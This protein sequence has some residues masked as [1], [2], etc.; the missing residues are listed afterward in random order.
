MGLGYDGK[1][2]I[3]AFDHRGSFQKK[4]FGIEGD[5]TP[6]ETKII[7]DAK[8]L[9]FEGVEKAVAAGLDPKT[10][11]VLVDEQF[12]GT[13]PEESK[14]HGLSLTMPAE[15]LFSNPNGEPIAATHSPTL[16]LLASPICTTGRFLASIL[17]S[18]TSLRGSA[19]I[20]FALNSRLSV[21]RTLISSALST[22]C[23]LVRM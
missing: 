9:I 22:T 14:K 18:A 11:G 13:I 16:A 15:M 3:L 6:E 4:M 10:A 12:G 1:L 23:A 19:P 20:T 5:P 8:Q 21:K 17:I 2:Y 7:V